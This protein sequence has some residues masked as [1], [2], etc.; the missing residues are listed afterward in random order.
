MMKLSLIAKSGVKGI[1]PEKLMSSQLAASDSLIPIYIFIVDFYTFEAG[2]AANL[3][4]MW[5]II[6]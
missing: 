5:S 4:Q 3:S 6:V 1:K 2:S